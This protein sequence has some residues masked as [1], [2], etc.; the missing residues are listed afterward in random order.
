MRPAMTIIVGFLLATIAP[1]LSAQTKPAATPQQKPAAAQQKPAAP[2]TKPAAGP[3]PQK[4]VTQTAK[5]ASTPAKPGV[6]AADSS[7]KARCSQDWCNK[8]RKETG[9]SSHS[10]GQEAGD[11][12]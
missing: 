1:G 6:Q 7:G 11:R 9:S 5:P 8:T 4:P 12:Y 2:A 3:A 10:C